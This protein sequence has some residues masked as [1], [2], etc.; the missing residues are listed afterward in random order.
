[1]ARLKAEQKEALDDMVS[2]KAQRDKDENMV[3]AKK[4]ENLAQILKINH[5]SKL[6][7]HLDKMK[8]SYNYEEESSEE[9]KKE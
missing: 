7:S 5:G 6:L 9:E 2:V 3:K 4:D 1:M 8:V